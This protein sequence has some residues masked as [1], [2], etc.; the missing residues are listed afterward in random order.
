MSPK[1]LPPASEVEEEEEVEALRTLA[2]LS[3]SERF[4]CTCGFLAC[5]FPRVAVLLWPAMRHAL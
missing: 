4:G 2:D 3:D 5:R 1:T